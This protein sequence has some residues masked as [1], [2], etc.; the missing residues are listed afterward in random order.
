MKPVPPSDDRYRLFVAELK[1]RVLAARTSAARAVNRD[2]VLLYWDLSRAIVEQQAAQ[3]WGD[4]V[5]E[6]LAADLRREFLGMIGFSAR[7]LWNMRRLYA[8]YA[9][10]AILP[11]VVAEL[12][13]SSSEGQLLPPTV[14]ENEKRRPESLSQ[15][16]RDLV[17]SIPWGHHANERDR[18][19]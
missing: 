14:A 19:N 17:V 15:A 6:R 10:G 16:V 18:G 11:W 13:N 12:G 3:G 2:L 4:S 9:T 7:S 5:A 8:E 1:E